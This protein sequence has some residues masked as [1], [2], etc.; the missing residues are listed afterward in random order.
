M[1]IYVGNL[2]HSSTEDGLRQLFEQFGAVST[3]KIIQDKFTG[4]SRGFAFVEMPNAEEAKQAIENT[5]GVDLDGRNLR[6]N[7]ARPV[8]A[9][10]D[11]NNR[12]PRRSGGFGG[13]GGP[14]GGG[15]R[16]RRF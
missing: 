7:E 12:G 9:H 6:V 14:R 2:S 13:F 10:G 3:V 8:E 5:N 1:N 4:A 11:R 16:N 15:D